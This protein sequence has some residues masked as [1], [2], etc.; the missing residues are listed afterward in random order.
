MCHGIHRA[1]DC[2]ALVITRREDVLSRAIRLLY[3]FHLL[4]S[5]TLSVVDFGEIPSVKFFL[6]RE[7]IHPQCTFLTR[8]EVVFLKAKAIGAIGKRD[9]HHLGIFL[10]LLQAERNGMVGIF[11]FHD[12]DG[13]GTVVIQY[14]VGIFRL[15]TCHQVTFQVNLAIGK[16]HLHLHRDILKRPIFAENGRRDKAQFDVFFRQG[17]DVHKSILL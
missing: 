14:I 12:G 4:I 11:G 5:H 7:F 9:V 2:I 10:G 3:D 1:V 16:L 6:G 15:A 13:R 17:M 8:K